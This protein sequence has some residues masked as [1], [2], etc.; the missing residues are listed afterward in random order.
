MRGVR[1]GGGNGNAALTV[2]EQVEDLAGNLELVAVDRVFAGDRVVVPEEANPGE[3]LALVSALHRGRTHDG[4]EHA[5]KDEAER[6]EEV[7]AKGMKGG[8]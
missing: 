6:H 2:T 3:Y 7:P 5:M 4:L 1:V 8:E